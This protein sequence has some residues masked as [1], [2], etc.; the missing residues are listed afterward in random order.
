MIF[1]PSP[2]P[3]RLPLRVL[4]VCE[5]GGWSISIPGVPVAVDGESFGEAVAEM[6][7]AL[8][9]YADDWKQ[10]LL[11]AP[12]HRGNAELV[13]LISL[14]DDDQLRGWLVKSNKQTARRSGMDK[15]GE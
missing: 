9:E 11:H 1:E 4:A 13:R 6:I 14:S 7:D 10:R 15:N 3:D 8:R 2:E 5:T 12:N